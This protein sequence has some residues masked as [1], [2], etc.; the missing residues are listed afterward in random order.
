MAGTRGL[1]EWRVV[2]RPVLDAPPPDLGVAIEPPA[3]APAAL[4]ALYAWADAVLLP[5]RFEG[6]P[7]TVLEAQRM[8]CAVIATDVGAV[9]EILEDGVDGFLVRHDQPES[10]IIAA[11]VA[12]LARLAARPEELAAIGARAAA[13]LRQAGWDATMREFLDHLDRLLPLEP[14]SESPPMTLLIDPAALRH[15]HSGQPLL[16]ALERVAE[17]E[18]LALPGLSLWLLREDAAGLRLHRPG[19]DPVLAVL[20]LPAPPAG[21]LALVAPS[22]EAAAPLLHAWA[23]IAPEAPPLIEAASAA[24]ALPEL[25]R[26]AVAGLA[27]AQA[28]AGEVQ[29]ALVLARQEG[30]EARI[31]MLALTQSANQALPPPPPS[32]ALATEPSSAGHAAAAEG[33]RL[34]LGQVL[35]VALEGLASLALH[36]RAA[37]VSPAARLRLRLYAGESRRIFGSWTLPAEALSPGWIGF[38][39]PRPIGPV[40]ETACLDLQAELAEGDR[41]SLSLEEAE[42]PP[43]QGVA[44]GARALALRLWTVPFGRRFLLPAH[45]NWEDLD[46]PLAPEGVPVHLPAQLWDSAVLPSGRVERV[47]LGAEAPRLLASLSGGERCLVLLPAVPVRGLDLLQAELAVRLG[48]A[49]LLEAALWLQPA[50]AAVAAEADLSLLA[51]GSRWSGW[52]RA[53]PAE[54]GLRLPLA[55]PPEVPDSVAVVLVLRDCGTAPEELLRVEWADLS[56]LRLAAPIPAG[57]PVAVRTRQPTRA[58]PRLPRGQAPQVGAV[59]LQEHYETPDRGYRHLDIGVEGLR[60]GEFAWPRLR[61][62]LALHGEEPVLEFR[63]RPD[64]PA[65]FESWPGRAADEYGPYLLLA[66]RDLEGGFAA[67]LRSER[68]RWMVFA[69]L[70]LLPTAVATAAREAISEPEDYESWLDLARRLHAALPQEEG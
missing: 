51:P 67:R 50:G 11:M 69:L 23:A 3:L 35:P 37:S 33:G 36:L 63:A 54:G 52:R 64:W 9:A 60:A 6:V 42:A 61:F 32:L 7:L 57:A 48:D 40:R 41:L 44:E 12:I 2:G 38:D 65:M 28:Q 27:R 19:T 13:R 24:A 68:D 46:L 62:K 34:I 55:L 39:L 58:M 25:A 49:A 59:R 4:D 1:V 45:W 5:S 14:C 16:L 43:G 26:L 18:A 56:G 66:A 22:R 53:G 21:V 17:A 31:A 47:A 15:L 29:Q 30:E 10:A 8:G 70:R 20:P